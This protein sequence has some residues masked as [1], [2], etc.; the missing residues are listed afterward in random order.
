MALLRKIAT[1]VLGLAFVFRALLSIFWKERPK[2]V[3]Y[4]EDPDEEEFLDRSY[5]EAEPYGRSKS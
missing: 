3:V 1:P 5:R 4:T 2:K